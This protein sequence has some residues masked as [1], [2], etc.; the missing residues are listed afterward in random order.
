MIISYLA[1]HIPDNPGL[2]E[3]VMLALGS[4]ALAK[5]G[6]GTIAVIAVVFLIWSQMNKS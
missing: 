5:I 6:L 1:V 3:K 2:F 4:A